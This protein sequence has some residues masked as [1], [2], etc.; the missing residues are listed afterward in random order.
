MDRG[1]NSPLGHLAFPFCVPK[2]CHSVYDDNGRCQDRRGH[3]RRKR[4]Q[5][6]PQLAFISTLDSVSCAPIIERGWKR[7]AFAFELSFQPSLKWVLLFAF[8]CFAHDRELA[9]L[10]FNHLLSFHQPCIRSLTA[11]MIVPAN[12]HRA[13]Y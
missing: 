12:S 13:D 4:G 7:S 11:I 8:S 10:A 1:M 6:R 9:A 2:R 5:G 3:R